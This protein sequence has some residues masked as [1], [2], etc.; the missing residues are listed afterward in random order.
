MENTF[1]PDAFI[2]RVGR[3]LIEKFDDAKT[4]TSPSTIGAA[5]EQPVRKQLEQMLPRGIGVGSGFIIDSYE[6][7]S[8]QADIV[9][10]EKDIC[11]V[12]SVNDTPETTYYPCECTVA[13][14]EV[15]STLDRQSLRDA[16]S[17]I[18]SVKKLKRH[19]T[20]HFLPDPKTGAPQ[21]YVYRSYGTPHEDSIVDV[22]ENP[23]ARAA[24]YGFVLAGSTRITD[25]TLAATFLEFNKEVGDVLSPNLLVALNGTVL[26]WGKMTMKQP[27]NV[28]KVNDEYRFCVSHGGPQRY[29]RELSA[30]SAELIDL[31]HNTEPFRELVR[32]IREAYYRGRTPRIS[33]LDRYF[34]M[35]ESTTHTVRTFQKLA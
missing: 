29:V 13:V 27:G 8:R 18:A 12:F 14:G 4:A 7:T 22:N 34:T 6:G 10:Y 31:D 24:V 28:Q 35:R 5:M 25:D 16:F 19:T 9:L 26:S 21:C 20:P 23:G 11:P 2:L 33:S 3:R 30:E 17:K 15:K 1:D 32:W